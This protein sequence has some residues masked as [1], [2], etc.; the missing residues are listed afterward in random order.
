MLIELSVRDLGVIAELQQQRDL[1]GTHERRQGTPSGA[2]PG[3]V[4]RPSSVVSC[5]S[6]LSQ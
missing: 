1:A 2:A 5:P 6:A 4:S 3:A